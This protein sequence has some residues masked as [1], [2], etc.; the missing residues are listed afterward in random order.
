MTRRGKVILIVLG[1][2]FGLAAT[3]IGG[4]LYWWSQHGEELMDAA[5]K[6]GQEGAAFGT[7]AAD[8]DTCIAEGL[9]RAGE[10]G[11]MALPCLAGTR[12]FTKACLGSA[13][14]DETICE[15]V[16]DSGEIRASIDWVTEQCTARGQG[17]NPGCQNVLSAL[18]DHCAGTPTP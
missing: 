1:V 12:A 17:D 5:R 8:A 18:Q 2:I 4:G 14:T 10:C 3:C 9:R 16:P 15:G 6:S 13:P 11:P 7:G